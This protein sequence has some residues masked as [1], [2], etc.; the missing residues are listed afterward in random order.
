MFCS[1]RPSLLALCI[2]ACPVRRGPGLPHVTRVPASPVPW[3]PWPAPCHCSG[4]LPHA[5]G[6]SACPML[7]RPQPARCRNQW[8]GRPF[9]PPP[10]S[11]VGSTG[12]GREYNV[13]NQKRTT[14]TTVPACL[15]DPRLA[16]AEEN[17]HFFPLEPRLLQPFTGK[18]EGKG[19]AAAPIPVPP[20]PC[21]G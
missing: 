11:T 3:E 6:T 5:G 8:R 7:G 13:E 1:A 4:S 20:G 16:E 2:P 14:V 15:T 10:L 9:P 18:P 17:I 21:R 19:V 12:Q